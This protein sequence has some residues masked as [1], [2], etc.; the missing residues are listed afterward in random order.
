[1]V[2]VSSVST[3]QLAHYLELIF[4]RGTPQVIDA[5]E[6]RGIVIRSDGASS[7]SGGGG[8][9]SLAE[10]EGP[11]KEMFGD[12]AGALVIEF[13]SKRLAEG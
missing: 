9:I 8:G 1:M 10:L 2:D 4:G 3:A 6:G 11:L 5:L 7:G 13:I 12:K